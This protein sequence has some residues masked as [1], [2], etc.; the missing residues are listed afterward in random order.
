MRAEQGH[1]HP[2]ISPS[3]PFDS[4]ASLRAI[5]L[6]S[7]TTGTSNARPALSDTTLTNLF[8]SL[9]AFGRRCV[10]T[11]AVSA[12]KLEGPHAEPFLIQYD[13]WGRR[14][15]RL[16]TGEGWR[17]LKGAAARER[18]V[19]EAYPL[20]SAETVLDGGRDVLEERA[21]LYQFARVVLFAPVSKLVLC[22][23]SMTDGAARVLELFGTDSQRALV[24][25]LVTDDV[26]LAWTAGQWMTE[27]PGGSDVSRTETVAVPVEVRGDGKYPA[28]S[29]FLLDG[30]KWFS[31]ATDGDLSLALAR[32]DPDVTK[33]SRGLSLFLVKLRDE[34]TGK[35]NGVRVH[36]LKKKMG[37][38]Y[39]PTAELE[40]EGCRA[41]LVGEIG[42]GV[43]TISSVLNITRL[44][45]AAGPVGALARGLD[46]STSFA[47]SRQVGDG[48][49]SSLPLHTHALF[50]VTVLHRGLE[51]LFFSVVSLLGLS[52]SGKATKRETTSLR[53]L[54]PA[55]KAFVA[56]RASDG[57]M[58][59]IESFGGQGYMEDSGLG[60]P[61]M[62]RDLTVERIW[63]GTASVLSLDV[64]RV[65]V[66]TKGA[67][68]VDF[69]T[70][71][72][73]R[74]VDMPSSSAAIML[75]AVVDRLSSASTRHLRTL[76]SDVDGKD[77]RPA[78]PLLDAIMAVHA[79]VLLL[80][81]A[82]WTR[83]TSHAETVK[84]IGGLQLDEHQAKDEE[85]VA[86]AWIEDV[87]DLERA[88]AGY[89]RAVDVMGKPKEMEEERRVVYGG[90]KL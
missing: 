8:T 56:T 12:A 88:L 76:L 25:R 37:T 49:L 84:R 58:T 28:G 70:S 71:S 67:A 15:D 9:S 65:L 1:Q 7:F 63:E 52:E 24:S 35:L 53:L 85:R 44:Y 18:I 89:E 41:E 19:G 48:P 90:S 22:P 42:R 11:H 62:L 47:R 36:R 80:E 6:K 79:S 13:A 14:V 16:E 66:Q 20:F 4:T 83:T 39:L 45:S 38:K 69:L 51:Q 33:G 34:A 64:L 82:H 61:E 60:L 17:E 3:N 72:K 46:L 73:D 10:T 68:M 27:R 59:L 5:L 78:R 32:T 57:I 29:T 74:I 23:I 77:H 54:T 26:R 75:I 43:S 2:P 87:G 31:S 86:A 50:R 21:R 30:F 55:L 40:L 81:Q